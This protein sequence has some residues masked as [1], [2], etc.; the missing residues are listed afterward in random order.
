ME[1]ICRQ[2][3]AALEIPYELLLKHF[4]SSYSASRGALEEA[5]KMFKM[6][7]AWLANDFCQPIYEEWLAEAVA[8]GR[9]KATGFF[10][11]PLRR[12]A[13]CKAQWNG[14]ARGLLNPVQEVGAAVTR[15]ENGF[16]TR[17]A[18]TME[19]AGGDFYSNCEQLKQEEKKLKEVKKIATG[20]EH[21]PGS[22][23]QQGNGAKPGEPAGQQPEQQDGDGQKSG[24]QDEKPVR[25][26]TE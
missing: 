18:E 7:R 23:G 5:W 17:S 12:K 25:S 4:T 6:Y 2:I 14:P 13:Y 8:K 9:I 22:D 11:D 26:D 10:T 20:S 21:K 1:A 19:M 16:S 15:V 24:K 3:G